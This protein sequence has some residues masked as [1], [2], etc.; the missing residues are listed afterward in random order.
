MKRFMILLTALTMT[1]WAQSQIVY[2]GGEESLREVI[3]GAYDDIRLSSDIALTE[4][5]T[6]PAGKDIVINLHGHNLSRTLITTATANGHVVSIASGATLTITDS[7]GGG[8]ITGGHAINGGAISN[9]GVLNVTGV[10]FTGN[11]AGTDGGA[12]WNEGTLVMTNCTV[13]G[14]RAEGGGAGIWSKG[15]A[16]LSGVEVSDNNGATNGGGLTNHGTM[17]IENCQLTENRATSLGGA[18]YNG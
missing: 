2:V 1:L 10:T 15:T 5:I 18:I 6:V 12:I 14:N 4:C 7:E 13:N 8:I 11:L 17:T 3:S 16:T 9:S